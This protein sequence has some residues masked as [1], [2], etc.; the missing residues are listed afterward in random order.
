MSQYSDNSFPYADD[1]IIAPYTVG[2]VAGGD[3]NIYLPPLGCKT[4]SNSGA[5]RQLSGTYVET[6]Y[7]NTSMVFCDRISYAHDAGD[8]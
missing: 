4:R 2:L 7:A 3:A 5:T 1:Q 6:Y 8:F